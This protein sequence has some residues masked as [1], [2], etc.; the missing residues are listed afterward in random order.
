MCLT[1]SAV[2]ATWFSHAT[3]KTMLKMQEIEREHR[4]GEEVGLSAQR[5]MYQRL[6]EKDAQYRSFRLK[7]FKF[8]GLS[9]LCNLAC[10]ICTGVNLACIALHLDSL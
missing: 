4:L 7:F 6:K 3:T 8:H 9:S 10:V 2:N 5:E 1:L